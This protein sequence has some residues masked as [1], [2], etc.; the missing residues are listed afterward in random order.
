MPAEGLSPFAASKVK[1]TP[2][3]VDVAV[4]PVGL[5]GGPGCMI[6]PTEAGTEEPVAE[7]AMTEIEYEVHAGRSYRKACVNEESIKV[8]TGCPRLGVAMTM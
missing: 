4:N 2:L 6:V 7:M 3:P 8:A 5:R 1:C